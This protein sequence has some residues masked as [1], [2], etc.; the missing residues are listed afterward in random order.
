MHNGK[1]TTDA[2]RKQRIISHC[3]SW[4]FPS[5]PVFVDKTLEKPKSGTLK[6]PPKAFDTSVISKTYYNVVSIMLFRKFCLCVFLHSLFHCWHTDGEW[7]FP[8][9]HVLIWSAM[10]V[11]LCLSS[12]TVNYFSWS[13]QLI[14][15][16]WLSAQPCDPPCIEPMHV[17]PV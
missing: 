10:R 9:I 5:L 16:Q 12:V 7:Q 14:V 8:L 4:L 6:S 2:N 1:L 3:V 11:H 13:T 17:S 15:Q